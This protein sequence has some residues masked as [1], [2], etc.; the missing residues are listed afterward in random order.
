MAK[1]VTRLVSLLKPKRR[2]SQF[3]L[4]TMFMVVTALC[5]WLSER[6]DP[7]RRLERELNDESEDTRAQAALKLGDLG[8]RAKAAEDSLTRALKDPSPWVRGRTAWAI[9]RI[10]GDLKRLVPL[11]S[12]SDD[13]IRLAAAEAITWGGGDA[14]QAM[15][16]LVEMA[17]FEESN[18]SWDEVQEIV[19]AL[20]PE[21]A[22]SVV[23]ALLMALTDADPV[24]AAGATKLLG[25]LPIPSTRAISSLVEALGHECSRVRLA[26]AE[27][28]LRIGPEATQAAGALRQCLRD[29]D[30]YVSVTAAAAL[31]TVAPDDPEFLAVLKGALRANDPSVRLR[32]VNYLKALEPAATAAVEELVRAI[33]DDSD[34][35]S[36]TAADALQ[37][38]GPKALPA[39]ADR[40]IR[41]TKPRARKSAAD[42]L[43]KLGTASS[44]AVGALIA[45]LDD[46]DDDVVLAAAEALGDVGV[47]A[48][49]AVP[50]LLGWLNMDDRFRQRTAVAALEKIRTLSAADK[51]LLLT[52]LGSEEQVRHMAAARIL[53]VCGEPTDVVV[54]VLIDLAEGDHGETTVDA[55]E[56]LGDLGPKADTAVRSLVTL[57]SSEKTVSAGFGGWQNC[58]AAERAL[59]RVGLPAVPPLI[60]ALR[61]HDPKVRGLAANALAAIGPAAKGAVPALID[62]L[63]DRASRLV[64]LGCMGTTREV[65]EDAIEALGRIGPE[66][67]AALPRLVP[68]LDEAR[69]PGATVD[70]RMAVVTALGRIGPSAKEMVAEL[71]ALAVGDDL[72]LAEQVCVALARIVPDN[73][74]LMVRFKRF[75]AAVERESTVYHSLV[76][77][78]LAV[79]VWELGTRARPLSSDLR[80]M[81]MER[82]LLSRWIRCHAAFALARFP[83]ERAAAVNYL[84]HSVCEDDPVEGWL[85]KEM[86]DK[87]KAS[88]GA[89]SYPDSAGRR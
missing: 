50:R 13:S 31:G 15:P 80:R 9:S 17:A 27:Q 6:V 67:A 39:L 76:L 49:P 32:S 30:T 79:V 85:V 28:L 71:E 33:D 88:F 86:L 75:L 60:D 44:G 55:L 69:P 78:D 36:T 43:A 16:A 34:A 81:A 87:I 56:A 70:P 65:R 61:H 19:T 54:R 14:A 22:A 66:A 64:V 68:M 20:G 47:D 10:G 51:T 52:A 46:P 25:E 7:I 74:R 26:A 53:A 48:A 57:L 21:S 1:P 62:R 29:D 73:D 2:W 83:E 58:E 45:A 63:D 77:D 37:R 41:C 23:P 35:V 12:D 11:L 4:A 72:E 24:R 59:E 38:M 42:A 18:V 5:V 89:A 82:P 40:L 3:S 8:S 84:E